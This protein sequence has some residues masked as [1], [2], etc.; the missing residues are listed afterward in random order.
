MRKFLRPKFWSHGTNL[1]YLGSRSQKASGKRFSKCRFPI[2][3]NP[4][5]SPIL[6][7]PR[8]L[9]K[10]LDTFRSQCAW[11]LQPTKRPARRP[12][13]DIL[14]LNTPKTQVKHFSHRSVSH[15]SLGAIWF[16]KPRVDE[17]SKTSVAKKRWEQPVQ[18][19]T[20]KTDSPLY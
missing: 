14:I 7:K 9:P 3:W 16:R 11:W 4:Y 15:C 8:K 19:S 6:V 5:E 20:E 1:G 12:C 10:K 13:I 18:K 2:I 17:I